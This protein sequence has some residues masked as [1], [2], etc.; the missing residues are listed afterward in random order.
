M[1]EDTTNLV[2]EHLRA[3]R[4][5]LRDV[6]DVLHEQGHRLTRI[7]LGLAS[8]RRDRLADRVQRIERR[9]EIMD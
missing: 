6:R 5:N 8:L 1:V 4:T 9:L 3:V 7:E 2:L